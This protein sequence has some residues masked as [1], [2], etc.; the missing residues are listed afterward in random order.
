M[1]FNTLITNR[2]STRML[3]TFIINHHDLG[4]LFQ[5]EWRADAVPGVGTC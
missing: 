1:Y 2:G 3:H 4:Q 5:C